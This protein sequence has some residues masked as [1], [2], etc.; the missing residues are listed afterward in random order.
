MKQTKKQQT[1]PVIPKAQAPAIFEKLVRNAD[2]YDHA[3][4][5]VRKAF[6][7]KQWGRVREIVQKLSKYPTLRAAYAAMHKSKKAQ[8]AA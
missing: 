3:W 8:R 6:P 2:T 5:M 4:A 7:R 1:T